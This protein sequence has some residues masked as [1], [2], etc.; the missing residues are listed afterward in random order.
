MIEGQEDQ[1]QFSVRVD[2]GE[3][4]IVKLKVDVAGN[5]SFSY[6]TKIQFYIVEGYSL[7]KLRE[8]C[9]KTPTKTKKREMEGKPI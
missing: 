8:L 7:E 9:H 1:S 3:D 2:P 5:G 6:S 4:E